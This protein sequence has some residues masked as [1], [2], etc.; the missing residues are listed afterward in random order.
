MNF[1]KGIHLPSKQVSSKKDRLNTKKLS[2]FSLHSHKLLMIRNI[3]NRLNLELR[4]LRNTEGSDLFLDLFHNLS[5]VHLFSHS[6][7]DLFVQ[8]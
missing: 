8:S 3:G 1:V 5:V 6:I 2:L 7:I 4:I